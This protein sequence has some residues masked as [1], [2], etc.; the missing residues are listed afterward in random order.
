MD[1]FVPIMIL[2]LILIYGFLMTRLGVSIGENLMLEEM[3]QYGS[4]RIDDKVYILEEVT[5]NVG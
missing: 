2:V 1:D 4:V 5:N 3:E